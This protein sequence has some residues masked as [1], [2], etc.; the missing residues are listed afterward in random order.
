MTDLWSM[1]QRL[2]TDGVAAFAELMAK[3]CVM[4]FGPMGIMRR[5]DVVESLRQ[6]P[7]WSTASM[8][9]RFEKTYGQATVV[10]AYHARAQK[11]DGDTYEAVCTST[12]IDEDGHWRMA[13]HQQTPV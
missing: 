2:W 3:D 13:Q 5:G 12:Y 1:E 11:E 10:L 9:S 6:A 8:S 4:V 7:R